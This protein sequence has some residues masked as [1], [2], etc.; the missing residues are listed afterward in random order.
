MYGM[1]RREPTTH[2]MSSIGKLVKCLDVTKEF[3][4]PDSTTTDVRPRK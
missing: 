3:N 4:T 1:K 2:E